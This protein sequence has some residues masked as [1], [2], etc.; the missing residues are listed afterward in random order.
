MDGYGL[1]TCSYTIIRAMG[2]SFDAWKSKLLTNYMALS[3]VPFIIANITPFW[4]VEYF[5]IAYTQEIMNMLIPWRIDQH[6]LRIQFCSTCQGV[7]PNCTMFG[8]SIAA[9]LCI[10]Y[11]IHGHIANDHLLLNESSHKIMNPSGQKSQHSTISPSLLLS[12]P[13]NRTAPS[14]AW[15]FFELFNGFFSTKSS[16]LQTKHHIA[17]KT[18]TPKTLR[19]VAIMLRIRLLSLLDRKLFDEIG[20]YEQLKWQCESVHKHVH[21]V[22]AKSHR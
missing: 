17:Q 21:N 16:T 3:K 8:Y 18:N 2:Y 15:L 1:L 4:V 22:S 13:I 19:F 10:P 9:S 20:Q 7:M 6:T 14:I 12:L 11:T 5:N